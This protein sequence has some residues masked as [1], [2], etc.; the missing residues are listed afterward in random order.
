M[1]VTVVGA[2]VIGLT[3][4]IRLAQDGHH[5]EVVAAHRTPRTTSDIAA[6]I[7]FPFLA[8]PRDRVQ[9]WTRVSLATFRE[10]AKDPEAA[11][12]WRK[13]HIV[14][15][16]QD[17]WWRDLVDEFAVAS[18]A[19][20]F[21]YTCRAPVIAMPMHMAF[22]EAW[23][24]RLGVRFV[25]R[26]LQSLDELT[27]ARL[28]VNA[29]GLGARRLA[30]DASLFPIQ[31]Q[32]AR[33]QAPSVVEAFLMDAHPPTYAIPRPDGVV[34]GG[35]AVPRAESIVA[36]PD[37]EDE[38]LARAALHVP[39]LA[40]APVLARSVGLRPGRPTIR[41]EIERS[42]AR[43]TIHNYGHGGSGVTLSW[44]CAAEVVRLAQQ[45]EHQA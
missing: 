41:L 22:L 4:A 8:E 26:D 19:H 6:A 9:A 32:V 18:S 7:H 39:A 28:V 14:Q 1:Q 44:G 42:A 24:V 10:L 36:D 40:H 2:G 31:G 34:V 11:V 16:T 3:S 15:A 38:L 5:V 30:R 23:A 29:S 20:G 25:E 37:V 13:T 21:A 12:T 45:L 35:T 43:P 17:A 33:V 27:A